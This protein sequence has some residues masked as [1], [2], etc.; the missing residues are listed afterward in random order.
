LNKQKKNKHFGVDYGRRKVNNMEKALDFDDILLVPYNSDM[1]S[2]DEV[3]LS[4]NLSSNLKLKFPIIASPMKGIIS[5]SMI[6]ILSEMGGIGIMHRFYD[7]DEEWKGDLDWCRSN[8][9]NFGVSIK[10][11]TPPNKVL[12]A[13]N[14]GAKIICIDV[15]NGYL[16]K[17]RE[18]VRYVKDIRDSHKIQCL[19]MA[20]SVVTADGAK[21]LVEAGTDLVRVGIGSG[22]LCTTRIATGVGMPQLTAIRNCSGWIYSSVDNNS[23]YYDS[24]ITY[25]YTVADGGI[26]N[27]GDIVKAI[28]FGADCVMIGSMFAKAYESSHNGIIYGMASRKLQEEYYH[29]VKSVEG[30]EQEVSKQVALSDMIEEICW[31]IK[32]ACTYLD[33]PSISELKRVSSLRAAGNRLYVEKER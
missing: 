22:N 25:R 31:D 14:S 2:R 21:G 16:E 29:S 7:T 4:V 24:K 26:R 8:A 30:I 19:I 5:L 13:L 18:V 9:E 23:R 3:D 28:A 15:A 20:G 33:A 6:A 10:L 1:T 17:V 27:S 12:W 32:S 11:D